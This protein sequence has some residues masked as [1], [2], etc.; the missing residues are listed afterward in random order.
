MFGNEFYPTPKKI[1][2]KM[3]EGIDFKL[4]SSVLEPSAGKGDIVES[5]I[6]K[7]EQC[8]SYSYNQSAKWDIDTVEINENLQHILRGRG[9]RVVHNDFLTYHTYKKYNLIVMNPPFSNGEKHLLKA[10]EMQQG[11]GKVVC[12]LNA[13]TLENPYSNSRKELLTK[14]EDYDAEVEYINDAFLDAERKTPVRIALIK[15]NIEQAQDDS[16]ILNE[17]RKEERFEEQAATSSYNQIIDADFIKGIVEQYNFEVRAGLKLIAEWR[18]LKPLMLNTFKDDAYNKDSVLQLKI[19]DEDR[20]NTGS[21]ENRYIEE[22]RMKYW[23]ALFTSDKF[24]GLFTSNLREKYY[25]KVGELKDY[26]FSLFNIYTIR[27][28]LSQEMIKAVEETIIDLFEEFSH[29]HYYDEQSKNIHYYN[30]WKTNKS[31]KINKK[32]IIPLSGYRDL[33]FSWGGFKPTQYEVLGKLADIEKVFNYLDGGLTKNVDL[34]RALELAEE[35]GKSKKIWLKYF[36]VTFY[37]KGTCHIEFTN[38]DLLHKFNLFGSQRKGWLPPS[39]GKVRYQEMSEEEKQV[40]DEFEGES[41]YN[42]VMDDA[43][44]FLV[45]SNKLLL[46]TG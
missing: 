6:K 10:L 38:E 43:E 33:E 30:G 25:N 27:I 29:K 16:I 14:L 40:I 18:A 2:D 39:Y 8:H 31:W 5:V 45:D 28:Q 23:R 17:L 34:T 24:M 42:D 3:L 32:V 7:L 46:L 20:Y 13:E 41:S 37:K 1:I 36:L 35:M 22:I 21:L 19:K 44:Y 9:C 4:V 11:G 26:D 15:V 12:L